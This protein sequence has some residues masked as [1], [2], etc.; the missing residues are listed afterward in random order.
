MPK[1]SKQKSKELPKANDIK[2]NKINVFFKPPILKSVMKIL[3]MEH[4]GFR[5]LKSVK[6]INR[7]FNSLDMS[8]YNTEELISYVWCIK[9]MSKQWLDG[10]TSIDLIW[11][12]A[13][14]STEYDI[15]KDDIISKSI[16]DPNIIS[17]P[18]AKAVF[19]LIGEALQFGFLVAIKD[20]YEDLLM[21]IDLDNPGAFREL[22][23]RLFTISQSLLDIK[24]NTNLVTNKVTF[25]TGD[26]DSVKES[27][28]QT[29]TSLSASNN[30]FK[31]GIK[32]LN[33][34]LSPG[35]M[36]GAIY[37]YLGLPGSGK[38]QPDD[39][40][41]PTPNGFKRLDELNIGDYIF[42]LDGEPTLI[43]GIFPQGI[44]DTYKV[45]FTDG[46]STRCNIEHL[47]YTLAR[48]G[49]TGYYSPVIRKLSEMMD[50]FERD[51][52]S[53][54]GKKHHKYIIPNNG[55]VRFSEQEVR[56]HPWAIGYIIG[57]GCCKQRE[58]QVSSP[59]NLAPKKIARILNK[60]WESSHDTNYS[61]IFRN[62]NRSRF[63]TKDLIGDIPE[64]FDKYSYERRIP[65]SYLYNT[66]SVRKELLRG[67]MDSDG[68]ITVNRERDIPKFNVSYSTSSKGLA[69]DI[70]L[71]LRSLGIACSIYEYDPLNRTNPNSNRIEYSI[72]LNTSNLKI[73]TLFTLGKKYELA[74]EAF[75]YRNIRRYE[76][77]RI[78]NIEKVE[79]TSQRCIM[80]KDWRHV[81]LTEDFIPTHN[82]LMLL[83]SALDIRKYN[84]NFQP[85]TPGM[86][87]A[88]LYITMENTFTETIE[89]IWNMSFDDSITNYTEEQAIEKISKELGID[90]IYRDDIQV[91]DMDTGKS[92]IAELLANKD[93]IQNIEV[94]VKY[95]TY[96]EINTDDLFVIIQD[97]RD[98]NLEVCALVVDYIKRI[99]PADG[100][101]SD[102]EKLE[103]NRA[104]NELKALAGIL[105][106]P[107]I[108]AHQMNRVAAATVDG[109]ARDGKG[110]VTKLVGREHVGSAFEIIESADWAAVLNIEYKPGSMD[111]R[112]LV[113]NVV[114]RRRIEAGESDFAKY[115]YIAH[116]FAK[117]NGFRLLDDFGLDKI[118]SVQSLV[119]DI[120]EVGKEKTN[121]T[122]RLKIMS[123]SEFVELDDDF[124]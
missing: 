57:N 81:Y 32:R 77:N 111:D 116:P 13:K 65:P 89:R 95:F 76:F 74:M 40:P 55:V 52:P 60:K 43:T 23:D 44:Q 72:T 67:L 114:K 9:Y 110:D 19:N 90:Y 24:H 53:D 71:L 105:D 29:I 83:K 49:S 33:T 121:A 10:I 96:R 123:P 14:R 100:V 112:Y 34:L 78:C 73:S 36:N 70:M 20:K 50:D 87:P 22:A 61:Y 109:A 82:S 5:T 1:E 122:E 93:D 47:W 104:I 3:T 17:A 31:V 58:F 120:N 85:K 101:P 124:D 35:Y 94:V 42:N 15:I 30:I 18:E 106:I 68:C 64:I 6:N 118:L 48:N 108:T 75:S 25:N 51:H 102:N 8:K 56:V 63:H 37:V 79:P 38:A 26:M 4:S 107:V 97:L 88:V 46:R 28:S 66:E 54:P 86:K 27:I 84:P 80:V 117:N 7:L 21:Q 69:E 12:G 59:D 98:E 92:E 99:R 39:T 119:T 103:L 115:T 62:Q 16:G 91:T 45:T 2:I 113:I 41:I 11:E